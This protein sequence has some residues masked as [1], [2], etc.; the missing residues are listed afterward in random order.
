MELD[1]WGGGEDRGG[2]GGGETLIYCMEN[3]IFN[4]STVTLIEKKGMSNFI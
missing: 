3:F 1:E 2:D 4:K